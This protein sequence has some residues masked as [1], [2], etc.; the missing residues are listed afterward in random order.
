[1]AIYEI[2]IFVIGTIV[3]SLMP[4]GYQIYRTT[5]LTIGGILTMVYG[6]FSFLLFSFGFAHL[7]A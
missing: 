3:M 4:I 6:F 5:N 1:M 7:I 2:I